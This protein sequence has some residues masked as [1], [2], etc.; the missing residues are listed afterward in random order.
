MKISVVIPIYNK[1][2]YVERC[3]TQLCSQDFDDF[4]IIAV[5]D[6]STDLSGKLCD[7]IAKD[8]IQIRV[9]HTVNEGVTAAR[10]YGI[11]QAKGDYVVF[12][13]SDDELLPGALQTLYDAIERTKA[14]EVVGTFRLHTGEQSPVIYQGEVSPEILIRTIIT[15]KN[16]FPI[17][18]ACIFRKAI[19][20]DCLD[21]PRD[22]IEGEDKMMQV[23][24]LM[25]QPKVYFINNCVY[26][27]TVGVPNSRRHTL[28]REMLYDRI[29]SEVLSPQWDTLHS[30]FV[31]HQLKEYEKFVAEG[32]YEVRKDYY[33]N[34]IST[35]PSDIPLYDK[36][37]WLLP[38]AIARHLINLYRWAIRW[39]K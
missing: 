4:E 29:L 3:L 19:L 30:A 14:D 18:W 6:G 36:V 13:D 8:H 12:V 26:Q 11:E 2:E 10:R 15:G 28:A 17:L 23:K 22:I 16:R 25:K 21:T 33:Q 20:N 32:Q 24:V 1:Q 34:V 9:F 35:L 31:L 27:Y 37:V 38:P 7:D 39:N 5:D